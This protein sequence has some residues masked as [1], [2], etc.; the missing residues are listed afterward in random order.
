M[1]ESEINQIEIVD[2]INVVR[3]V[4]QFVKLAFLQKDQ[5]AVFDGKLMQ[6]RRSKS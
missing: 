1:L 6:I 3:R 2:S 4:I 5:E